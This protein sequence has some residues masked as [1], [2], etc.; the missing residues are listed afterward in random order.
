MIAEILLVSIGLIV[1]NLFLY[2][3][4]LIIITTFY[5]NKTK[6]SNFKPKVSL[7]ISAYN[8]EKDI[9]EKIENSLALDYDHLEILIVSDGSTDKTNDICKK[10]GKKIKFY[11]L[12][13][14]VGKINALKF[15][16]PKA[17][18]SILI[19][20][21]ANAFYEKNVVKELVKHFSD[22]R[23]GCVTGH[24][25][26]VA[27]GKDHEQGEG[28]YM[29]IEKVIMNKESLIHSV[30]GL[31]GAMY[32]LRKELFKP[33]KYFIED[34]VMGMNVIKNKFRVIYEPKAKG[35]EVSSPGL[36]VEM[37]RK[38]RIVAGGF[39]SL[40]FNWFLIFHPIILFM[41][42]SHK[43]LRWVTAELMILVLVLNLL[44]LNNYYFR[45]LMYLQVL[46]YLVAFIGLFVK[47]LSFVS[48]F[49]IMQMASLWGF[50]KFV[51]RLQPISWER[52]KRL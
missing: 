5:K 43:F 30:I 3:I 42:V 14:N 47:R 25:K 15:L 35:W 33:L 24:V 34:F 18:G 50:I 37:K 32:A 16:V 29:G 7:V 28:I 41:F 17:K 19:F 9:K 52:T 1:Y 4:L 38:S 31:D 40:K 22:S 39:Q 21:D 49:V 27:S 2:P 12:D 23:I 20:S 48:Y 10:Y 44:L 26:L 51:F 8:E 6:T 36:K 45:I 11:A 46:F 13:K